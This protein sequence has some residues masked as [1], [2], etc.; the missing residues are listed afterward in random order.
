MDLCVCNVDVKLP[1]KVTYS[2]RNNTDKQI[3]ALEAEK[4]LSTEKSSSFFILE[5]K[6]MRG[7]KKAW[8]EKKKEEEEVATAAAAEKVLRTFGLLNLEH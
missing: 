8:K 4:R 1:A 5:C 2:D 3:Y 6:L 7:E